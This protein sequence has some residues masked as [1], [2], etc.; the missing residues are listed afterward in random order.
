[1][2]LENFY[3]VS[4][5]I[6]S[7]AVL[8]SLVYLALQTR[9]GARN[10]KAQ[11]HESRSQW[12]RHEARLLGDPSVNEVTRR[13]M[14]SDLS[15]SEPQ[16]NQ[17][18]FHAVSFYLSWEEQMRQH[19]EGM[20][21]DARWSQTE[22]YI[23]DFMQSPGWRAVAKMYMAQQQIDPAYSALLTRLLGD[24]K[25]AKRVPVADIW[26]S[27]VSQELLAMQTEV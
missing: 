21:D 7:V 19:R 15:M 22:A 13:G 2:S 8:A 20:I 27:L 10:Q 4:Q 5:I 24:V 9:M 25:P 3:Y 18:F 11:M 6:A 16:I 17:F 26:K 14:A 1:M 23:R 12:L